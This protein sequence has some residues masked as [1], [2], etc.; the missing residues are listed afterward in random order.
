MER[1]GTQHGDG[2]GWYLKK[3]LFA[4]VL[5]EHKASSNRVALGIKSL[6]PIPK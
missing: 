4:Q 6:V 3:L 1:T 5:G 2:F